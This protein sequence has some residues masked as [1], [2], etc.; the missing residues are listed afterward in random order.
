MAGELAFDGIMEIELLPTSRQD[1]LVRVWMALQD[2][3]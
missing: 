2:F 3:S 1:G